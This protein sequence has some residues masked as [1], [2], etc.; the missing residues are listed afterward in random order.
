MAESPYISVIVPVYNAEKYLREAIESVI[1]QTYQNWELILVNDGS[2]D[3]S[4]EICDEYAWK[5]KRI[6]VIH[7][8]NSG[9]AKSR[10]EGLEKSI[11]PL[12]TFMDA[13]DYLEPI[14]LEYLLI[15]QRKTDADI[16]WADC[17]SIYEDGK[18]YLFQR[19]NFEDQEITFSMALRDVLTYSTLCSIWAKLYKR[20]IIINC[21]F[22]ATKIGEDV[23]WLLK[24]L[25]QTE[26]R[27]LRTSEKIYNYR[28]L[29]QSQSHG[30]SKNLITET[31]FFINKLDEFSA[32]NRTDNEY[33]PYLSYCICFNIEFILKKQGII[34][35]LDEELKTL[36]TKHLWNVPSDLRE[37]LNTI[38][39]TNNN[40]VNAVILTFSF[41]PV[42]IKCNVK[43]IVKKFLV[44][45]KN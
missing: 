23:L 32:E 13:D 10:Q 21:P 4:A 7:K 42:T 22:I 39:L 43:K 44:H 24:L 3:N 12:V 30:N 41:L 27:I 15:K 9:G 17:Q 16:I 35:N 11:A 1:N 8:S 5:D 6:Q 38:R 18:K 31:Y 36:M 25:P 26:G 28:I 29:G 34:K 33:N 2:T 37:R 45:D 19:P 40:F 20:E 14:A